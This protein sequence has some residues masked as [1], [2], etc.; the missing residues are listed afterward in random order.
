MTEIDYIQIFRK[1]DRNSRN[2]KTRRRRRRK[3]EDEKIGLKMRKSF[4]YWIG[5]ESRCF[6]TDE[7][8]IEE[9][10]RGFRSKWERIGRF[11]YERFNDSN[12]RKDWTGEKEEKMT[13]L[14]RSICGNFEI[15]Y[16][17]G[18][19]WGEKCFLLNECCV[20]WVIGS[21]GWPDLCHA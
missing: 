7:N 20:C 6:S 8:G 12:R 16:G 15:T 4:T 5:G 1:L 18:N 10:E 21:S 11:L 17:Y 19:E 14:E 9:R 13:K 3:I 2:H